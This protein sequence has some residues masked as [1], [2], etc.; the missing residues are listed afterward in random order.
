MLDKIVFDI[1]SSR[2]AEE[3]ELLDDIIEECENSLK[4]LY[5]EAHQL[6]SI[7]WRKKEAV[8]AISRRSSNGRPHHWLNI[9]IR[10]NLINKEWLG[11][12][13][14]SWMRCKSVIL[15]GERN[16]VVRSEDIRKGKGFQYTRFSFRKLEGWEFD[17]AQTLEI[18]FA[19]IRKAQEQLSKTRR[20][21]IQTQKEILTV[22][23]IDYD[24]LVKKMNNI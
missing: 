18:E 9:R 14:I 24:E 13:T 15:P 7:F 17:I 23:E 21:L 16:I 11:S 20:Q 1:A 22:Q 3:I 12:F 8:D 19:K 5:G 6:A 2:S 4:S 10:P